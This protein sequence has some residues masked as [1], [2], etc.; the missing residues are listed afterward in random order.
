MSKISVNGMTREEYLC[1]HEWPEACRVQHGKGVVISK[2]GN[3][4]TPFFEAFP[5]KS[6]TD[7]YVRGE[8]ETI[9][10]SEYNAYQKYV[11]MR[12]CK[13][14]SYQQKRKSRDAVCVHCK[15]LKTQYYPPSDEKKCSICNKEAVN[16][17]LED[18]KTYHEEDDDFFL[19]S[20]PLFCFQHYKEK[21][22][23]EVNKLKLIE[24]FPLNNEATIINARDLLLHYYATIP[25]F[26]N[27]EEDYIIG[28]KIQDEFMFFI[29]NIHLIEDYFLKNLIK[30]GVFDN[31]SDYMKTL[32]FTHNEIS[33]IFLMVF[34]FSPE[35]VSLKDV[36]ETGKV[37][38]TTYDISI[39]YMQTFFEDFI[40]KD[41]ENNGINR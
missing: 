24:N 12:D 40:K 7:G 17:T 32:L 6:I 23:S 19:S 31:S 25:Y 22:Q 41:N 33:Y 36:M 34:F 3:Y 4:K 5:D 39:S 29:R 20:S 18:F 38:E 37:L 21:L 9:E 30:D 11:A 14:H 26:N 13:E 8:G 2:N 35:E 16:F 15:S 27:K 1:H 10:E 28:D